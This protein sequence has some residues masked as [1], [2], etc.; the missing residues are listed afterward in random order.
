MARN[1]VSKVYDIWHTDIS[2]PSTSLTESIFKELAVTNA[3]IPAI[4]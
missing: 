4:K 3:N 2:N 1:W